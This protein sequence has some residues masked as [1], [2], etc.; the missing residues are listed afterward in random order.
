LILYEFALARPT[1]PQKISRVLCFI[2]YVR[3][4]QGKT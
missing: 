3:A 1:R 4:L 2:D